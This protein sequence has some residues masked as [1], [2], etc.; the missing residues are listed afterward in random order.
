MNGSASLVRN[1]YSVPTNPFGV[2]DKCQIISNLIHHRSTLW[3]EQTAVMSALPTATMSALGYF[4]VAPLLG[5]N[6]SHCLREM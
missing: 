3:Q 5:P 6:L 4:R 2:A 1:I